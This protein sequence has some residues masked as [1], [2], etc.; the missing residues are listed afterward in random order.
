MRAP[1]I[2]KRKRRRGYT[3]VELS[4]AIGVGLMVAGMGLMLLNQQ[5]AFLNIFRAQD[6]LTREAPLINNYVTRVIGS[7]EGYALYTDMASLQGGDSAVLEDATVLVLRYKLPNGGERAAILSFEDPG[8]GD[9]LYY[10]LVPDDGIIGAPEL[11]LSKS[12][13]GVRFFVEQG[14]LRMELEGPAGE[15]LV[16]SGTQ[17]L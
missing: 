17:Q 10:R 11:A 14:V 1:E 9:G 2:H 7:A 15:R 8:S 12:P 3:L 13:T 4:L 6:F 16:Y 5:L